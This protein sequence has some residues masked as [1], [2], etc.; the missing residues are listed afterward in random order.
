MLYGMNSNYRKYLLGYFSSYVFVW[1]RRF[2]GGG[3]INGLSN[4]AVLS[5]SRKEN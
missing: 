4:D 5:H 1:G 3:I 2:V